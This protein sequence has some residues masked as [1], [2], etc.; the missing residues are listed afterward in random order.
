LYV[1]SVAE[2]MQDYSALAGLCQF[3]INPAVQVT[4]PEF[5]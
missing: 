3:L 4:V 1:A 5:P 2:T